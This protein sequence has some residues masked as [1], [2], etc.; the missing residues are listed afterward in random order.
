MT[1][2]VPLPGDEEREGG[3][4][5]KVGVFLAGMVLRRGELI[6]HL[7]DWGFEI[8]ETNPVAS[9]VFKYSYWFGCLI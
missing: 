4:D 9:N 7:A 3:H 2:L 6:S 1:G 8:N 5:R